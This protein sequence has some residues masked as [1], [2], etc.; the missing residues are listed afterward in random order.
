MNA[1]KAKTI[2]FAARLQELLD[3]AGMSGYRLAEL[4]GLPRQTVS[5]FLRGERQPTLANAGRIARALG[6]SL[7]VFDCVTVMMTSKK[8]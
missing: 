4:S 2:T 3:E 5:R 8:E 7:S 1:M 6:V